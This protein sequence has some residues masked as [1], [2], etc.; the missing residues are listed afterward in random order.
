MFPYV[1]V[2]C[3]NWAFVGGIP[4]VLLVPNELNPQYPVQI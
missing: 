4:V 2:V 1:N 3:E